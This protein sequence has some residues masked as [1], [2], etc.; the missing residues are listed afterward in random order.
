MRGNVSAAFKMQA[1]LSSARLLAVTRSD[2]EAAITILLRME[3]PI[4]LRKR[5][6][7]APLFTSMAAI[8]AQVAG[9][10]MWC[11][12]GGD[13]GAVR[14]S[15]HQAILQLAG[16]GQFMRQPQTRHQQD[17][18]DR[19]PRDRR[20]PASALIGFIHHLTTL[21]H[22]H[23]P[24][25]MPCQSTGE[26]VTKIKTPPTEATTALGLRISAITPPVFERYSRWR[27]DIRWL[28]APGRCTPLL[29]AK[30]FFRH[31]RDRPGDKPH[32]QPQKRQGPFNEWIQGT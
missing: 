26:Y 27:A 15:R 25:P 1:R 22:H 23:R 7:P 8:I 5:I 29:I 18:G 6:Q 31:G 16:R 20:A 19:Q 21:V 10:R 13:D 4:L 11:S 2:T 14:P 30:V 24:G 17:N 12:L 32:H 9:F 28:P 3:P